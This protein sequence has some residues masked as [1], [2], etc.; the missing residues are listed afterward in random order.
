METVAR[1]NPP[2]HLA[3][4]SLQ[5]IAFIFWGFPS[6]GRL[7][8]LTASFPVRSS[9]RSMMVAMYRQTKQR[10]R[11]WANVI[12]LQVEAFHSTASME[13]PSVL[14]CMLLPKRLERARQGN[15]FSLA[16]CF[17][18]LPLFFFLDRKGFAGGALVAYCQRLNMTRTDQTKKG[19]KKGRRGERLSV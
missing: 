6:S 15:M 7:P 8:R 17:S 11:D 3:L 4:S 10:V 1:W 2:T 19:G 13:I 16:C 5:L 14:G 9:V 12:W 18:S